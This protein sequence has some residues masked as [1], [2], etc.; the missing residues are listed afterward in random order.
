MPLRQEKIQA[1]ETQQ[2]SEPD[3]ATAQMLE[4]AGRECEITL[5]DILGFYGKVEQERT[6][7]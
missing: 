2:L 7:G 6:D 3:T 4:V 1:E 5:I